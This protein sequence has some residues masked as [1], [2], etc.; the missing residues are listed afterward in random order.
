MRVNAVTDSKGESFFMDSPEFL[1]QSIEK[2]SAQLF[3][4]VFR[5]AVQGNTEPRTQYFASELIGSVSGISTSSHNQLIPLSNKDY[6]YE[7]H[8]INVYERKSNRLGMLLN[9][10]EL[11]QFVHYPNK[12]VVSKKL[13]IKDQKTKLLP[14]VF[15]GQKYT[16]GI[17]AHHG[18]ETP[19]T[20]DDQARLRHMHI[21]GA[22]G[23]GKSTFMAQ[24]LI[25]DIQLGNGCALFDPHGDIVEDILLRIPEHRKDD[26]IIVDP[27]DTEFPIG[28]NILSAETEVEKIVLSSDIV[29]N[30]KRYAT[31]WGDTMTS[32]LSNAINTFLESD[33]QGT[34]IE[35]KRFLLESKFREQFL[36][37][38]GDTSLHYYWKHEYPMLKRG[39]SPLLTRIDTFLR[40]KTIRYMM[41]NDYIDVLNSQ[42]NIT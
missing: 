40:P 27:S 23:V 6:E 7:Q 22:T 28:F 24:M 29:S 13:G 37:T 15:I 41:A 8:V 38:V 5:I 32:V 33:K 3:S 18:L 16:L 25:E 21:I 11:A 14:Q 30:F 26:V 10:K 35:L 1:D 34:L 19:V 12:T 36:K 20:I 9:T 2:V 39:I 4:T 42:V 17:N 31:S